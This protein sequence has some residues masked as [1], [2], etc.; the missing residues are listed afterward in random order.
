MSEDLSVIPIRKVSYSQYAIWKNCK[1]QWKLQY[2]DGLKEKEASIHLTFGTSIH[3][4]IQEFLVRHFR[5]TKEAVLSWDMDAYFKERLMFNFAQDTL[6][7][8][9]G[10]KTYPSTPKVLQ[11][12]YE[13]GRAIL[14]HIKERV[15]QFFP[16]KG[17]RLL[18]CEIPLEVMMNDS[19]KFV[20]Y[21]D[22]VI[23]DEMTEEVYIYDLKT[24][25]KGW[26][27]E[28]KDDKKLNQLLLYKR[29]YAE[30]F[31]IPEDKIFVSFFILKRKVKENP[32]WESDKHRIEKFDPNQGPISVRRAAND[33]KEFVNTTFAPDGSVLLTNIKPS[34]SKD[35]C[36]FCPFKD[37][38][39]LC[40]ESYYL[41]KG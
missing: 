11:E 3:E 37:D 7:D 15:D 28:K 26:I 8:P 33:L 34:P 19:V 25:G 12:F 20:A 1:W 9:D 6:I 24:S 32:V 14:G 36:R 10:K 22:I 27:Y 31:D 4:T 16:N 17:F 30:Q 40:P 5:D 39:L 38:V 29:Y 2:A 23:V 35:T 13:D 21:L 41:N 18:G